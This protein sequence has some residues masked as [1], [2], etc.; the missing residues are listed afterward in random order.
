M[1]FSKWEILLLKGGEG[2]NRFICR[3]KLLSGAG[4]VEALGN[5]EIRKLLLVT[6]PYFMKNGTA[7]RVASLA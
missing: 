3:T 2:L 5:M 4:A 1:I 7:S 6:D